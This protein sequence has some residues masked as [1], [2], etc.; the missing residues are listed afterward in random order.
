[1]N[2]TDQL[3]GQE[4]WFRVRPKFLAGCA[5]VV[6]VLILPDVIA[7]VRILEPVALLS[8]AFAILVGWVLLLKDSP[9][10]RTWRSVITLI[11][12]AYM[13]VSLPVF[14]FEL[15]PWRWFVGDGSSVTPGT[16]GSRCTQGRGCIGDTSLCA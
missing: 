2:S 9:P 1:M 11:A 4:S 13:T 10:K 5:A 3:V 7:R 6:V 16:P 12:S 8:A 14:L 15:S